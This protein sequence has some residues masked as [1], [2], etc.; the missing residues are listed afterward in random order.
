MGEI[1]LGDLVE[2]VRPHAPLRIA[3][4]YKGKSPR[5]VHFHNVYQFRSLRSEVKILL[6]IKMNPMMGAGFT[7]QSEVDSPVPGFTAIVI[8]QT[9]HFNRTAFKICGAV[10]KY[11]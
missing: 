10:V 6:M 3:H 8:F 4:N 11:L 9:V 5:L 2:Y 7:S 1:P